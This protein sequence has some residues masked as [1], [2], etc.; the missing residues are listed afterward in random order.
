[1]VYQAEVKKRYKVVP[2][3]NQA[4]CHDRIWESGHVD[5]L[6]LTSELVG[7]WVASRP[8]RFTPQGKCCWYPLAR[9]L[10]GPRAS[11]SD[12]EKL[13][14]LNLNRPAFSQSLYQLRYRD[15]EQG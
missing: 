3:L 6:F 11:L 14:F 2:V 7:E 12:M 15:R 10:G 5:P 4:L 13:K 8:C 1:M 9:R